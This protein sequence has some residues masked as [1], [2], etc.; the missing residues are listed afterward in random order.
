[1]SKP[2]GI[3]GFTSFHVTIAPDVPQVDVLIEVDF[4][5]AADARTKYYRIAAPFPTSGPAA[6]SITALPSAPADA[7]TD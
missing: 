5:C 4:T 7:G 3:G 1:M 2:T 6:I